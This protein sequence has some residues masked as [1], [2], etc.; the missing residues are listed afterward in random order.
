VF[1]NPFTL[2]EVIA[3]S[4]VVF[5]VWI[6]GILWTYYSVKSGHMVDYPANLAGYMAGVAG[7]VVGILGV[8]SLA[9]LKP[10]PSTTTTTTTVP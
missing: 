10:E 8:Q 6:P 2:I 3:L 1:K 7:L 5:C 4:V 9:S